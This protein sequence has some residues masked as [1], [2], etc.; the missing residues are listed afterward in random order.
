MGIPENPHLGEI[1]NYKMCIFQNRTQPLPL[2]FTFVFN[3]CILTFLS[4]PL[5]S[6]MSPNRHW[7]W[8]FTTK[9]QLILDIKHLMIMILYITMQYCYTTIEPYYY[10]D[11]IVLY[12]CTTITIIWP[13]FDVVFMMIWPWF[14]DEL[15]MIRWWFHH[16]STMIWWFDVDTT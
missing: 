2:Y 15:M 9:P 6:K 13:W 3:L 14:D 12:Y 7:I 8:I 10:S 4:L 1:A 5:F 11:T 16:D